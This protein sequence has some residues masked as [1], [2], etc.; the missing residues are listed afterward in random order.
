MKTLFVLVDA[1]KSLYLTEENMPFL[2]GLSKRAYYIR[3]I[4]PCAGFCERSEIFTGLDGYDTG[5]FTAIGFMPENSPYKKDKKILN[6]FSLIEKISG[7][8]S[9]HLFSRWR[10][11]NHRSLNKYRIPYSSLAKFSLTEDGDHKFTEYRSLFQQLEQAHKTYTLDAFTSL[12]DFAPRLKKA[13]DIFANDEMNKETY[14]IPLYIGI[15]DSMGHKFGANIEGLKPYLQ[16]IDDQLKGLYENAQKKGYSF[17]VMGDHGMVPVT[18]RVDVMSKI[19]ESPFKHGVDFEVFYDSTMVRLWFFNKDSETGLCELLKEHFSKDGF[20]VDQS[21]YSKYRIPLDIYSST[22]KPVYGNLVWCANP[23]VL[24]SPDYFHPLK[25]SD[26]GMHGY[27]EVVD[28]HSTGLFI[29]HTTL[30]DW[31]IQENGHSS[32]VCGLLSQMLE[33]EVP[34]SYIWSRK[35]K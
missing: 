16:K 9:N 35:I 31:T 4:I 17:A 22:G 5:N 24:V 3:N 30:L 33:V 18:K 8:V 32:E 25:E 10:I 2:Y 21:N 13:L 23:G 7:R 34:N 20:I 27:I 14:F 6:Y 19:S 1:L 29:A 11:K 28:G 26:N 15:I 12:A